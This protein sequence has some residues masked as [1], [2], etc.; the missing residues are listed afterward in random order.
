MSQEP[1]A[2]RDQASDRSQEL[3]QVVVGLSLASR[4]SGRWSASAR[5]QVMPI[6][7]PSDFH[8]LGEIQAA[9]SREIPRRA[10]VPPCPS[11]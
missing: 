5:G 3:R 4:N 6:R 1:E 9:T 10:F 2:R 11:L 7:M 8:V